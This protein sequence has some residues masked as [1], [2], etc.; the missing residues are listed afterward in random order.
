ML[1]VLFALVLSVNAAVVQHQPRAAQPGS[2]IV[3]DVIPSASPI[4]IANSSSSTVA[5]SGTTNSPA[6]RIA[7][8]ATTCIPYSTCIDG[9]N[10]CGKRWGACFDWHF[11]NGNT[12]PYP[13]PTCD[14]V[15]VAR[16]RAKKRSVQPRKT[17][18]TAVIPPDV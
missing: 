17:K 1:F 4:V 13:I 6:L 14:V 16:Y 3:R 18:P 5:A 10:E 7:E 8:A 12:T 9:R 11:C 2:P 15:D